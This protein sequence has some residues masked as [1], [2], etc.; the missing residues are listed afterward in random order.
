MPV[1]V[2]P[3][4]STCRGM[5]STSG[6]LWATRREARQQHLQQQEL[7]VMTTAQCM[8]GCALARTAPAPS[9][10][11]CQAEYAQRCLAK[12]GDRSS[13]QCWLCTVDPTG[14]A[15]APPSGSS[16]RRPP[17]TQRDRHPAWQRLCL[18]GSE[19]PPRRWRPR[20]LE[21]TLMWSAGLQ[22]GPAVMAHCRPGTRA[23]LHA[24]AGIA[25]VSRTAK[26]SVC[27]NCRAGTS[28]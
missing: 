18:R 13:G 24:S 14:A 3:E 7:P 1:A 4:S 2:R 16:Q 6:W 5:G 12:Y 9:R 27:D 22:S 11:S 26:W 19:G 15:A 21:S 20:L 17:G 10:V 8:G 23:T 28:A 25:A